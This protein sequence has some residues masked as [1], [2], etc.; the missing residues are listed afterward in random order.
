MSAKFSVI[1]LALSLAACSNGAAPQ[2][3]PQASTPAPA[4]APAAKSESGS[5]PATSAPAAGTPA[6]AAASPEQAGA[7][8]PKPASEP[9]APAAAEKAA[10]PEP[11]FIEVTIPAG[12]ALG[13]TLSTPVASDTSKVE[14]TVRGTLSS[15]IVVGGVT[16]V[17]A[18]AEV[19]G[20]VRDAK[21]SG[22]V[23][24]RA[25]IAFRF[26][27]LVV[28]KEPLAIH[29][30]A[31]SRQAKAST[32]KD[33]KSG[34]IGGGAGA[35][36]GGIV[37]GGKGAAIG[38]GVGGAGGVLA[39]RGDEVRLAAGTTVRTTLQQPLKVLVPRPNER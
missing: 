3:P 1:A 39:T 29:T 22:R 34:A 16:A 33:V 32:G 9:A 30:A 36:I 12:T 38:A 27:R 11:Q 20:T 19:V 26:D 10:P 24:G 15:P 37:G 25:S 4:A 8:A 5:T 14:D 21:R 18:G 28:R 31:V 6:Q 7:A 17:P 23:K 13:V 35:I 2:A